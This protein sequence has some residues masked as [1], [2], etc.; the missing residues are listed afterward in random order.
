MNNSNA[1]AI[2]GFVK[3]QQ[4]A[5]Q[6]IEQF[7]TLTGI[8]VAN[9]RGK[10]KKSEYTRVR[11]M[12]AYYLRTEMRYSYNQIGRLLLRDHSAIIYSVRIFKTDLEIYRKVRALYEEYKLK[13]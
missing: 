2:P 11:Q 3:K 13:I 8:S 7:A 4:N 5:Q 1:Y 9:I 10:N 12:I 6:I